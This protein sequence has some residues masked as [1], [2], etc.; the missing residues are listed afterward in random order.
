MP[1]IKTIQTNFSSGELSPQGQQRVDIA[2]YNSAAKRMVNVTSKTLGGVK[3]R[4]GSEYLASI[5]SPSQT[6]RLIQYTASRNAAYMLEFSQYYIRIYSPSGAYLTEIASPYSI[7]QVPDIDYTQGE[8]ALYLFHQEVYPQRLRTFGDTKWDCSAAPFTTT[9]FSEIGDYPASS[10]TLSDNSVGAGRTMIAASAVFLA[11]DVGRAITWG[12]GIAVITGYT[13]TTVIT[14]EVNVVFDDAAIPSGVWNLDSSPHATCTPSATGPVGAIVTLTLGASGW[15]ASDVG[16]FVRLNNGLC[17]ITTYSTAT[18]VSARVEKELSSTVAVPALAWTL[19]ASIWG[20]VNGFPRTGTFHEQ[21]LIT[22]STVKNSQTIWGSRSGEP[23]DYT[24]GVNDADAWAFTIAGSNN[25][26]HQIYRVVSLRNLLIMTYGGEFSMQSG[27]EKPIT[28]TN[29]QI[30][31]QTPHGSELVKPVQIGKELLF[32]QRAGRRLRAMGYRYDEDGYAAGDLTTLAEH[33]TETGIAEVA[34]QQEPDPVAWVRLNNGRL[35]S[36]TLDRALDIIAWNRHE[37]GGAVE[38]VA[39]LPF[40]ETEQVWLIVR[41]SVNGSTVRYIERLQPHFYPLY[42]TASPSSST[43]PIQDE[44]L[45]WGFQLDCAKTQ[46]FEAGQ[47]TWGGLSHLEGETVRVLADG[48]DMGEFIVSGG[49]VTLPRPVKRV[50]A[51]L[52]FY[53]VVELLTP[54]LQGQN[55][56]LQGAAMSTSNVIVRVLNS[57]SLTVNGSEAIPGRFIGPDQLDQPPTLFA[58]DKKLSLLGWEAGRSDITL[59]Q[60]APFPWHLLSVIRSF[61]ANDGN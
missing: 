28:P 23:L 22:A 36:L 39:V 60:D 57:L 38:S 49:S 43:Y 11:S 45:D 8:D 46:D 42:G 9:P 20:G 13:S 29:V 15:R 6:A 61:T 51:G 12:A 3:K 24:I 16:K 5:R 26:A 44:P 32:V 54:E 41:R 14:V 35:V 30:K 33:I 27:V 34:F 56:T 19:E 37:I 25:Q 7:D 2:R 58:G 52:M 17:K 40:E 48:V 1:N 31:P 47:E 50:L 53:P 21:R 59:S 10:L 55:G 18:G 4:P